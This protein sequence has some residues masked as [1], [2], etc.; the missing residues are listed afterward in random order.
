MDFE[1][2]LASA[3]RAVFPQCCL[4]RDFFHFQQAIVKRLGRMG[5]KNM[6][7]SIAEDTRALWDSSSKLEF[8][9]HITRLFSQWDERIPQ[10]TDYFRATWLTLFKPETWAAYGRPKDAPSGSFLSFFY[11]Y[12]FYLSSFLTMFLYR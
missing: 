5:Y 10:F 8:D 1:Q 4:W 3:W 9:Q 7:K 12:F 11:F 2:A 6:A